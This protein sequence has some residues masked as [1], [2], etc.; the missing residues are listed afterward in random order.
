MRLLANIMSAVAWCALSFTFIIGSVN[1]SPEHELDRVAL[2]VST[3]LK[4]M[5]KE[6]LCV[7]DIQ[8]SFD[9]ASYVR[10]TK[11]GSAILDEIAQNVKYSVQNILFDP[12]ERIKKKLEA[13]LSADNFKNL[14][15]KAREL[16][17]DGRWFPD[18]CQ[19]FYAGDK[20]YSAAFHRKVDTSRSCAGNPWYAKNETLEDTLLF[21]AA[22]DEGGIDTE[23]KENALEVNTLKWQYVGTATGYH[24]FYPAA[25]KRPWG[26]S[27]GRSI[28]TEQRDWL[29]VF[30][31]SFYPV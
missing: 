27:T 29:N 8:S 14:E 25:P 7:P 18:L 28:P 16:Y 19:N 9:D 5:A 26:A 13:Q 10:S 1:A 17:D 15:K 6:E 30:S 2:E 4:A 24:R 20:P 22:F 23:F 12:V 11:N 3:G 21:Q 31:W